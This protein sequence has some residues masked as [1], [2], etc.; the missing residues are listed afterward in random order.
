MRFIGRSLNR[1]VNRTIARIEEAATQPDARAALVAALHEDL[2]A[3]FPTAS[4]E[5]V[6]HN[7]RSERYTAA[8]PDPRA[9]PSADLAARITRQPVGHLIC[10]DEDDE[11]EF[12]EEDRPA[13]AELRARGLATVLAMGHP[14]WIGLSEGLGR[15]A[16]KRRARAYL[17]RVGRVAAV[18]LDRLLLAEAE[19]RR[20]EEL[21]GL[22]WIAQAVNF[23]MDVDDLLELI[24][25]QLCRL[26]RLPRFY[27]ALLDAAPRYGEHTTVTERDSLSYAFYVEGDQRRH[28][29]RPWPASRGLTRLLLDHN[30]TIRTDDYV[31]ECGRRGVAPEEQPPAGAW[32]GTALTA[33]DR[34]IGVMVASAP[35]ASE[36]TE[37]FAF[38][39]TEEHL[40]VTV[41][42]YVAAILERHS[43]Y[44]VLE[45]R[46]QQLATLNEI[47]NLLA[48]SLDLDEVLDLVVRHAAN[49]LNA[50]AGSLLLSNEATGDLVFRISSGPAGD[51]LVGMRI[52]AGK[53]IAGAAFTQN[54]PVISDDPRQDERWYAT[55]DSHA[56]FVTQSIV[57]VP[58]NARGKTI[59]VLE[60]VNRKALGSFTS[61]DCELLLSFAAQAAIAIENA[62]LFTS[63]DRALQ[64]RLLELTTMQ[65]IDRQLNA[66]LDVHAVMGQTLE[67]SLHI[68]GATTGAVAAVHEDDQGHH[69]LRF[70]AQRG[71][72]EARMAP[73]LEEEL[74]STDRGLVGH[75]VRLGRTTLVTD[76][77]AEPHYVEMQP[78]MQAQLTVP[79]RREDRA[80]GVIALESDDVAS[81]SKEHVS[82]VERLADH[83]AIAIDNARLFEQVQEA[84]TAKTEFI[85]FV[86]HELKQPMTAIKGYADLLIKGVGGELNAQ[87]AQ[88]INVVRNN[89]DRMDR[90]VQDLLDISRI[91]AGRLKL[92][93]GEIVPKVITEEALQVY[94]Q[95]I[96]AKEQTLKVDIAET[97]PEITG[98]RGRLIQVLTNLISNAHKYTPEG[99]H[100]IVRAEPMS[101]GRSGVRWSVIDDGIGMT[102]EEI[103]QLFTKYFRSRSNVVRSVQGTGLGLAITRSLIEMHGGTIEVESRLDQGSTFS[104][105]IPADV[106]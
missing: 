44:T 57:A 67:W 14:G 81:F 56:S 49:L 84:D 62:Q 32:I 45:S 69:G 35:V 72:D 71:Y 8:G 24:H 61:E 52:P 9:A 51:K 106:T 103:N 48:S 22:Y 38:T 42:A 16:P 78:G 18:R 76:V 30:M 94:E 12:D 104:F 74:W 47:G 29:H 95:E 37:P 98:D 90:L 25:T 27:I 89:V 15:G 31:A 23:T 105:T 17:Q 40:F 85:S 39:D 20:E 75:T 2:T 50:E 88:F 55:F 64:A 3:A 70:L 87:Q 7:P 65:Y 96:A 54:R 97:L 6:L 1:Q 19:Q 80:I 5:I 86:S 77:A 11:D 33:Q 28:G 46:A 66:T 99:G 36:E 92:D 102:P 13:Y 41:A 21:R 60:V 59:G 4:I 93:I 83:A 82:F 26:V 53:G 63:T 79:I 34:S 10:I 100:I 101:A 43:L 91:E 68:T 58:L 73:Y